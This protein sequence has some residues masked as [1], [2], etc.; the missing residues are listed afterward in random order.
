MFGDD[1][2]EATEFMRAALENADIVILDHNHEYEDG[3]IQSAMDLVEEFIEKGFRGL[4]CVRMEAAAT[5]EAH[6]LKSGAALVLG[7]D[8]RMP[9]LVKRIRAAHSKMHGSLLHLPRERDPSRVAR[10]GQS[11][12]RVSSVVLTFWD[13]VPSNPHRTFCTDMRLGMQVEALG[14]PFLLV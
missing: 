4:V 7:K 2:G 10:D 13:Q 3:R 6:Y 5:D 12:P 1:P 9:E 11:N 8:L 14:P